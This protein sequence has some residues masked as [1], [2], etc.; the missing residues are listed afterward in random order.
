MRGAIISFIHA[1]DNNRP[2]NKE[3]EIMTCF[4]TAA[5]ITGDVKSNNTRGG[6]CFTV[7]AQKI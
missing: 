1:C 7:S 5:V 6:T 2:N 3:H 4:E